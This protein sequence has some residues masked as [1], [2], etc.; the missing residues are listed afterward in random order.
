MSWA[1]RAWLIDWSVLT[2]SG[3]W[4]CICRQRDRPYENLCVANGKYV[5][6]NLAFHFAAKLKDFFPLL[7]LS[8]ADV[9]RLTRL[10]ATDVT[11]LQAA[12]A[13]SIPRRSC[14][15]GYIS[16]LFLFTSLSVTWF[17]QEMENRWRLFHLILLFSFQILVLTA[18]LYLRR[19]GLRE[20]YL[21]RFDHSIENYFMTTVMS[22]AD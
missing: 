22:V 12:I 4:I 11:N 15:S 18:P 14:L 3:K 17:C 5:C 8:A 2:Y 21:E 13:E 7:T 19:S 1:I 9:Q 20:V 10:S 16:F 6:N